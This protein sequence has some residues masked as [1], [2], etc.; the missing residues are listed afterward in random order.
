M[1]ILHPTLEYGSEVWACNKR[2]TV[3]WSLLGS[4][5]KILGCSSKACN[6][7]VSGDMGLESL[8]GRRDRCKLKK[9]LKSRLLLDSDWE[10]KPRRGKQRKTWRKVISELLLQL[11]LDS[12][13]LLAEDYNVKFF[14][15]REDEALRYRDFND[16]L[17]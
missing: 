6:K 12:Q 3:F 8:K 14:S 7:A 5:K 16:G 10:V 2:Q 9:W 15:E 11:N 4:A 1:S 17:S 13:E